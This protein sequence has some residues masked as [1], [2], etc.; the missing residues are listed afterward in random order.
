[1][2]FYFSSLAKIVVQY[3]DTPFEDWWYRNKD[4]VLSIGIPAL[5]SILIISYFVIFHFHEKKKE[6]SAIPITVHLYGFK[7]V[8]VSVKE[9]FYPDIPTRKGYSFTGWFYDPSFTMPFIPGQKLK[10]DITLYPRWQK[11]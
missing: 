8:S 2:K 7:S 1:M 5:L 10:K 3:G 11:E 4:T 9:D 6:R